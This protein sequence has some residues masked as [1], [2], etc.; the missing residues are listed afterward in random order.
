MRIIQAFSPF[1][2][3]SFLKSINSDSLNTRSVTLDNSIELIFGGPGS[4]SGDERGSNSTL[5]IND[6]ASGVSGNGVVTSNFTPAITTVSPKVTFAEPS[7][8]L[9]LT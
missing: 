7:A 9:E 8:D 6:P 4:K 3:Q 5:T 2:R 1:L